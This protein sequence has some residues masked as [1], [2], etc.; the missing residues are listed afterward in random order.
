MDRHGPTWADMARVSVGKRG[1]GTRIPLQV[2]GCMG[3]SS[4]NYAWRSPGPGHKQIKVKSVI[5]SLNS[6]SSQLAR[7]SLA[8]FVS[9]LIFI[10]LDFAC[11]L[12]PCRWSPPEIRD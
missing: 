4:T 8:E 11:E 3:N 5:R 6:N 7:I 10:A 9:K 1:V 2:V 12:G